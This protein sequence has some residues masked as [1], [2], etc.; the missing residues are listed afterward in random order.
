MR[1]GNSE[2]A[3]LLSAYQLLITSRHDFFSKR[4]LFSPPSIIMLRCNL[5]SDGQDLRMNIPALE[6]LVSIFGDPT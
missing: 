2:N 5:L 6:H 1:L 4:R 3:D